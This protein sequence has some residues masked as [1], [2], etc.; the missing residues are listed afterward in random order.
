MKSKI[1]RVVFGSVLALTGALAAASAPAA[2]SALAINSARITIAGTSNVHDYTASTT[3]ARVTRVQIAG[4][5]VGA[6]FWD[7]VRLPGGLLAFDVTVPAA[8]LKSAKEGIDKNMHKALKVKEHAD[9][10]FTFLRMEGTPAALK[11]IG[12]LNIAGVGREVTL[13]LKTARKGEM[14]EVTGETNVL[15]TDFGVVPPKAMMGMV[16]TDP[17]IKITFEVA[18]SVSTT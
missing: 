11:A 4:A 18:L 5:T 6:A 12:T 8:S 7:A 3:V 9:I 14:L 13:A 17:K 10:T 15:M 2:E 1:S 16:K